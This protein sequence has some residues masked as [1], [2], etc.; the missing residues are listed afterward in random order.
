MLSYPGDFYI[1]L[2][3]LKRVPNFFLPMDFAI[4][5]IR[6]LKIT[7]NVCKESIQNEAVS[8]NV[9]LADSLLLDH[10]HV[11]IWFP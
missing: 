7:E 1:F 11:F 2:S 8:Q 9:L 10:C 6:D 3:L 4:I 5:V